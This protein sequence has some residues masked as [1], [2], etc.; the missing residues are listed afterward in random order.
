MAGRLFTT[1]ICLLLLKAT[2]VCAQ[3]ISYDFSDPKG[4][5][6]VS[7]VLNAMLEPSVG[8][9]TGVEGTIIIDHSNRKIIEGYLSVPADGVTMSNKSMTKVLH[10]KDWLNTKTYPAIT[11]VFREMISIAKMTAERYDVTIIGD[12]TVKGITKNVKVPVSITFHPGKYKARNSK[13][14]GDIVVL[15]SDFKIKRSDYNLKPEVPAAIVAEFIE[16]HFNIAGSFK[17]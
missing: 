12:L 11:F 15:R 17:K 3:N 13:G 8:F 5:N 2:S 9:A 14:K 16:L 10:S 4:V 6:A 1:L 7:I